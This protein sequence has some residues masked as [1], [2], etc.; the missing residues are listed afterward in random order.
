MKLRSVSVATTLLAGSLAFAQVCPPTTGGAACLVP[1]R[2]ASAMQ[3]TTYTAPMTSGS[4]VTVLPYSGGM[5]YQSPM[6]G[7][8]TPMMYG[9][10]TPMYGAGACATPMYGAATGMIPM[11]S[12]GMQASTSYLNISPDTAFL[13]NQ[14]S[15]L[16]SDVRGVQGQIRASAIEMRGQELTSRVNQLIAEETIFRQQLAAN[17]N[18]PNA[19]ATANLLAFQADTLNRDLAAYNR[20]IAMVPMELRPYVANDLNTFTVA[21]WNPT[22]QR[23]AEYRAQFSPTNYQHAF[24]A[25]PWLQN[26]TTGYQ[27]SLNN[28]GTVQQTYAMS[29]WWGQTSMVAGSMEMYPGGVAYVPVGTVTTGT[30]TAPGAIVST[31]TVTTTPVTPPVTPPVIEPVTPPVAPPPVVEPGIG[32]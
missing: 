22:M 28:I 1:S 16:R 8:A 12:T 23:F 20:E 24:A 19:Q 31:T 18:L 13:A 2:Q 27:T 10:A 11:Y 26:W 21:Y 5:S 4:L 6:Y 3:A 17:P 25:N 15:A 30:W 14:I 32:D 29:S 7:M 9:A